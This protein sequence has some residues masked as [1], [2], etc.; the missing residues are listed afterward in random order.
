LVIHF[1]DIH[2]AEPTFLDLIEDVVSTAE[3]SA[4]VIVCTARPE[5]LEE[6]PRWLEKHEGSARILLSP[7]SVAETDQIADALLGKA[8]LPPS[9]RQA[10]A[11]AAEGNPLFVEQMLS[12]LVDQG[13]LTPDGAGGLTFAGDPA[14]GVAVPPTIAAL[15]SARL[16]RLGQEDRATIEA[17]S[18]PGPIFHRGA[19]P[20]LAPEPLRPAIPGPPPPPPA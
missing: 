19:P 8:D 15:L 2:W 14:A 18:I 17:G 16:D 9:M 7:L 4:V 3:V 5:L 1:E 20:P 10:I 6:R 13:A 12:M 11:R